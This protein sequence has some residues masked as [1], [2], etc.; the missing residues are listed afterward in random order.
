MKKEQERKSAVA[1][2]IQERKRPLHEFDIGG[3]F[4]LGGKAIAKVKIRVATKAEAD[5]AVVGAHRYVKEIAGEIIDRDLLD[6]AKTCHILHAVVRDADDPEVFPAFASPQW[7]RDQM[8][9]DQLACILNLYNEC[10]ARE[11]Q[12]V[13]EI[14]DELVD[15]IPSLAAISREAALTM[16]ANCDR[17]ALSEI[18]VRM[19]TNEANYRN[20][21]AAGT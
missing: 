20:E 11:G 2:A 16:L 12:R 7:V 1:L 5:Q 3:F 19:A 15:S 13:D 4:G 8:S 17:H 9:T 10:V 21:L 14:T 18:I 6:D